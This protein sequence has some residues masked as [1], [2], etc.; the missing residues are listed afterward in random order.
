MSHTTL[1]CPKNLH[2]Q[3]DNPDWVIVDCRF[4]LSDTDAGG[5]AYRHGHL[6]EA[7]YAHL[8]KDL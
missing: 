6:P 3:M 8:D 2:Q 1:I 5:Y 7:R 4:S